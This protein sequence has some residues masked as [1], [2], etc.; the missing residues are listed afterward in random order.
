MERGD[1]VVGRDPTKHKL[2]RWGLP[3][4]KTFSVNYQLARR[5]S[6]LKEGHG[7]T[8]YPFIAEACR[9]QTPATISF[10]EQFP[11]NG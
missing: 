1:L 8:E 2:H 4:Y 5:R 9:I 3:T 11:S 7:D 6:W 10:G